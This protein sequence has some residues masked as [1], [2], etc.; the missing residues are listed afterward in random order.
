VEPAVP[1]HTTERIIEPEKW[2]VDLIA[3]SAVIDHHLANRFE[4][5]GPEFAQR[6]G[7]KHLLKVPEGDL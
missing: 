1:R 2:F 6:R 3:N 7:A 5:P 4:L